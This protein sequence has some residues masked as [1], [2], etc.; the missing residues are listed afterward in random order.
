M[1][2][3]LNTWVYGDE[4]Q[5]SR[6]EPNGNP[7]SPPRCRVC[8]PA[9]HRSGVSIAARDPQ[10]AE[11]SSQTLAIVHSLFDPLSSTVHSGNR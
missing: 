6:G 11:I 9:N 5:L 10:S 7:A 1:Q 3:S 2:T 8:S 4:M